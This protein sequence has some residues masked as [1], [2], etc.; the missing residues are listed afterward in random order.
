MTP[1]ELGAIIVQRYIESYEGTRENASQSAID[2]T[3]LD[4]LVEAVEQ[5]AAKLVAALPN[6]RLSVAIRSAW[7]RSL[8][9]FDDSYVDLLP[10]RKP[11]PSANLRAIRQACREVQ[12]LTAGAKPRHRGGAH[13]WRNHRGSRVEHLLPAAPRP[14]C[15]LPRA[16]S[17]AALAVGGLPGRIPRGAA[18]VLTSTR[19]PIVTAPVTWHAAIAAFKRAL[20]E[21]ALADAGG[22]RTRAA[23]SLGLRTYLLG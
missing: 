13:R 22:N 8:R 7:R 12:G 19:G 2:L 17:R 16:G 10:G 1:G 18:V 5:L 20:I 11:G 21:R 23:Q 3:K 14:V 15:A 4:D 9:C 6:T